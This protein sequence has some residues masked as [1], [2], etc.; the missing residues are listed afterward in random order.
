MLGDLRA[1]ALDLVVLGSRL[2]DRQGL[3]LGQLGRLLIS[4][5]DPL[6]QLVDLLLEPVDLGVPRVDDLSGGLEFLQPLFE[7]LG[8][9]LVSPG[10][11][12][13]VAALLREKPVRVTS[14]VVARAFRSTLPP[15]GRLPTRTRSMAARI[16]ASLRALSA[17]VR[18]ATVSSSLRG[19]K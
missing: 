9:V 14:A 11:G 13:G 4:G 17:S 5:G 1:Q 7:L 10:P 15:G 2:G 12:D 18:R 3:G 6:L 19:R 16:A 8:E